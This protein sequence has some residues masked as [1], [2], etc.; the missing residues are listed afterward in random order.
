MSI[1]ET[2]QRE[3]R[4]RRSFSEAFKAEV[5]ELVRQ[6]GDTA[7]SV[8]R[9][10]DLTETAVRNWVRQA[11]VDDAPVPGRPALSEPSWPGCARRPGCL[12]T[13]QSLVELPPEETRRRLED[14]VG[15]PQLTVLLLEHL[16]PRVSC[17]CARSFAVVDLML[18]HPAAQRL[19][20]DVELVGDPLHAA[21]A[22][23]GLGPQR[24]HDPYRRSFSSGEYRRCDGLELL[25]PF[26]MA[27][28]RAST[29]PRA[30]H[31]RG[32]AAA[33]R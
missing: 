1:M 8:A 3:R 12:T 7:A 9:D 23:T 15:P 30:V 4:P 25:V 16:D 33:G 2:M 10:L 27:P 5:V 32:L 20:P 13:L 22:L 24:Q 17:R 31:S 11:E 29:D 28:L 26:F 6:P 19:Y 21:V 14:L 18:L